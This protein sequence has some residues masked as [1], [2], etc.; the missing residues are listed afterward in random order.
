M[1]DKK[2][3][4]DTL[5]NRAGQSQETAVD[6]E[7]VE[8]KKQ[9]E[10]A[11]A[12]LKAVGDEKVKLEGDLELEKKARAEAEAEN[13]KLDEHVAK[14]EG[15]ELERQ[16]AEEKIKIMIAEGEGP[17]GRDDVFVGVQGVGYQ[18]KRAV[19]VKVPRSVYDTLQN[20]AS[21]VY[22]DNGDGE[23]VNLVARSVPRYNVRIV[24]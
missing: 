6:S 24:G 8:L 5:K 13:R 7:T 4:D 14:I 22:E 23:D 17:E 16:K 9:L 3:S 12:A 18:I 15:S 20:A 1:A 2:P 21:T 10:E 11:R 19:E